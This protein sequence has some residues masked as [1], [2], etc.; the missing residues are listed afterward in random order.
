M[1]TSRKPG[2]TASLICF[3]LEALTHV[4]A[5][6]TRTRAEIDRLRHKAEALH[7]AGGDKQEVR[8]VYLEI[9]DLQ[10]YL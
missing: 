3:T 7:L 10:Q 9:M 8:S 5:Q 4:E 1:T 2:A 6:K